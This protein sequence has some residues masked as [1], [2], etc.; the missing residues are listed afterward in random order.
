M[1][2]INLYFVN[3]FYIDSRHYKMLCDIKINIVFIGEWDSLGVR[4]NNADTI[5]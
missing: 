3:D 4:F 1:N 2:I 5:E